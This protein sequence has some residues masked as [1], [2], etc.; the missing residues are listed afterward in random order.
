M[1]SSDL[2]CL[3]CALGVP[4]F[5]V[6]I[7]PFIGLYPNIASLILGGDGSAPGDKTNVSLA[8]IDLELFQILKH[9]KL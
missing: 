9:T 1:E 4:N 7:S 6:S 8:A 5:P 3:A 2:Y